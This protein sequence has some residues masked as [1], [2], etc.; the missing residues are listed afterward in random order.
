MKVAVEVKNAPN[1][2]FTK[3]L[4]KG[5]EG[6]TKVTTGGS[7]PSSWGKQLLNWNKK[8]KKTIAKVKVNVVFR[9]IYLN[10]SMLLCMLSLFSS[11]KYIM[12]HKN[13][14]PRFVKHSLRWSCFLKVQFSVTA[15][16]KVENNKQQIIL[17]WHQ[18]CLS[19]LRL[20]VN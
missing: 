1:D 15:E 20:P 14:K 6:V 8:L 11:A 19:Q 12:N 2:E 17:K 7:R 5:S 4:Q 9:Y 16:F 3:A 10:D 18:F 13:S